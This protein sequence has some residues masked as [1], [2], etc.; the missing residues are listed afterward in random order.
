MKFIRNIK[1]ITRTAIGSFFSFFAFLIIGVFHSIY[2][3]AL[4][5]KETYQENRHKS[6]NKYPHVFDKDINQG[7]LAVLDP[8][9]NI[10]TICLFCNRLIQIYSKSDEDA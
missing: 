6:C 10:S 9:Y 4:H 7:A 1:I 2:T 8:D 5:V 3:W